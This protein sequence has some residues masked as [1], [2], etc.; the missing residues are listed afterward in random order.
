MQEQI[1][2]LAH[3][4]KGIAD[5]LGHYQDADGS[6][7]A[8]REHLGDCMTAL[9]Q[10][11][12]D[13]CQALGSDALQ[14]LEVFS[15]DC[16]NWKNNGLITAPDFK[17]THERW[18]L[19]SDASAYVPFLAPQRVPNSFRGGEFMLTFALLR[20]HQYEITDADVTVQEATTAV[21][22][23]KDIVI[24]D[25]AIRNAVYTHGDGSVLFSELLAAST[26]VGAQTY[27]AFIVSDFRKR[28]ERMTQYSEVPQS[29][30]MSSLLREE[31]TLSLE[32]ERAVWLRVHD[33]HHDAG[34]LPHNKH[35]AMKMKFAPAALDELKAD[36]SAYIALSAK[37]EVWQRA[38]MRQIVDKMLR[39]PFSPYGYASVDAAVGEVF[40]RRS[41][42]SGALTQGSE[43]L[44]LDSERLLDVI[45]D[46][47]HESMA[48]EHV[49]SPDEYYAKCSQFMVRNSVK[50]GA[51]R[52]QL[53]T[54]P[55]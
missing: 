39:F 47:N 53:T 49:T 27:G 19:P 54:L 55:T 16:D 5:Q 29:P 38:A 41:L 37:N 6:L 14:A 44:Q 32:D 18:R 31:S 11:Y 46:I 9:E 20:R 21:T 17:A 50:T 43:G 3:R 7:H 8:D 24:A 36:S 33:I 25:A 23:P 4:V 30:R 12:T 2:T 42:Q 51:T 40:L 34:E 1:G 35:L 45:R 15:E 10:A 22:D 13:L 26:R 52:V 28:Y 48:V